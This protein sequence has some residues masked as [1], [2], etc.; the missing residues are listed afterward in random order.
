MTAFIQIH[1]L[2]AYP[3]ANLNRD[4]SGRPK[5]MTFGGRER[6]RVSSQSLKRAIRT[7]PVF[8][9]T[10]PQ[11]LGSRARSFGQELEK[12]LQDEHG[13]DADRAIRA[14]AEVIARN[15]LGSLEIAKSNKKGKKKV[16]ELIEKVKKAKP[17]DIAES[18]SDTEQLAF[19]GPDEIA[20][21]KALAK[22][23]AKGDA[24]DEK[25]ALVLLHKPRAVDVALF[26]RMLA[27]NP[28]YNVEAA[29]QVAHSFTTHRVVVEDDYFT[30]VDQ[31]KEKR[32]DA[33]KGAGY[34]GVQEFG[35]GTFYTYVCLDASLLKANL[36][37]D[38]DLCGKAADALVRAIAYESPKGKQNSYASRGRAHFM[39]VEVGAQQPRTLG[40]AF[41]EPVDPRETND[42][43]RAS[44][45]ALHKLRDG[46]A[47]VYGK[48]WD[49]DGE[50][51]VLAAIDNPKSGGSLDALAALAAKAAR[52]AKARPDA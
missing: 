3:A 39:L 20:R 43:V 28:G 51:D 4:D 26:G 9:E 14:A 52:N 17:E 41:Q 16:A 6:L 15:L 5:T 47:K 19:L 34:V 24:L 22:Q 35:A 48:D 7:G 13:W 36:A 29:A 33:D 11:E 44:I 30:A 50:L 8:Q 27:D 2:T 1:A 31:L 46:F 42:V 45:D 10:F 25:E 32:K 21:L 12:L 49:E 40:T 23:L 37:G 18:R 38:A